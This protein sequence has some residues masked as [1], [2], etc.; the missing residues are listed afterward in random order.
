MK[1]SELGLR[2]RIRSLFGS[3]GFCVASTKN[4]SGKR[5]KSVP[6]AVHVVLLHR[7]EQG[8]FAFWAGVRLISVGQDHVGEERTLQERRICGGRCRDPS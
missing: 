1:R 3:I 5:D 7:F 6:R 2:Q 4:G 8:G